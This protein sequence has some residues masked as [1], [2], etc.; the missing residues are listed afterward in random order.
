MATVA[1]ASASASATTVVSATQDRVVP[2]AP[3][4]QSL[5]LHPQPTPGGYSSTFF[6]FQTTNSLAKGDVKFWIDHFYFESTC[7]VPSGSTFVEFWPDV[8]SVTYR[9]ST[10][11]IESCEVPKSIVVSDGVSYH[12]VPLSKT[13]LTYYPSYDYEMGHLGAY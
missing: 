5:D 3:H 9:G 11:L 2:V 6:N 10:G 1:P 8:V 12:T 4:L 13:K 7:V